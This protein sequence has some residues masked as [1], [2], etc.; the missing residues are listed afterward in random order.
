MSIGSL[1]GDDT[2]PELG[3]MIVAKLC[4]CTKNH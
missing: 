4:E 1:W 2:I 3:M